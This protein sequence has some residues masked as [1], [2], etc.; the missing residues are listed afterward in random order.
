MF[1]WILQLFFF[2][3]IWFFFQQIDDFSAFICSLLIFLWCFLSPPD[4]FDSIGIEHGWLLGRDFCFSIYY[5]QLHIPHPP[6][7]YTPNFPSSNIGHVPYNCFST[8]SRPIENFFWQLFV[9]FFFWAVPIEN[10]LWAWT[11][12]GPVILG[13]CFLFFINLNKHTCFWLVWT[14]TSGK[15]WSPRNSRF[16]CVSLGD[17]AA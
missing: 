13:H 5:L 10:D 11:C 15:V 6:E 8:E 14:Q 3:A 4:Y 2:L 1:L 9:L 16:W 17:I 12:W 7:Q